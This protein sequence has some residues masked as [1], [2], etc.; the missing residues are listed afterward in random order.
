MHHQLWS[1]HGLHVSPH[2]TA[3]TNEKST[4]LRRMVCSGISDVVIA[5]VLSEKKNRLKKLMMMMIMMDIMNK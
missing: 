3:N 5:S 1:R 2:S 4:F